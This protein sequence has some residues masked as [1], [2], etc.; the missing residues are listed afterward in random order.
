[1]NCPKCGNPL[2]SNV[3]FCAKCGTPVA[4]Q[5]PMQTQKASADPAVN[6]MSAAKSDGDQKPKKK[7]L[8]LKITAL[9][10]VISVFISG[11]LCVS[12]FFQNKVD[13]DGVVYIDEHLILKQKAELVVFDEENFPAEEYEITV[14]RFLVGGALK[15]ISFR[16]TILTDTS[17]DPVYEIDFG[18]DG[19]YRIT[20]KD[21]T[22]VRTQTTTD[23]TEAEDGKTVIIDVIVDNE[24]EESKDTIDIYHPE[25]QPIQYLEP[26]EE[27]IEFLGHIFSR[28]HYQADTFSP[29]ASDANKIAGEA[30]TNL[31]RP[32]Y[33]DYIERYGWETPENVMHSEQSDPREIY[34]KEFIGHTKYPVEN[35]N[36]LIRNMFNVEPKDTESY[37]SVTDEYGTVYSGCSWYVDGDYYYTY[38]DYVDVD[39]SYSCELIDKTQSET[40][41][42][43]VIFD[44]YSF[45]IYDSWE[46]DYEGVKIATFEVTAGVKEVDGRRVWSFEKWEKSGKADAEDE[47]STENAVEETTETVTTATFEKPADQ[48]NLSSDEKAYYDY[49]YSNYGNDDLVCFADVTHDGKDEMIVG[50]MTMYQQSLIVFTIKNGQV[51]KI[52]ETEALSNSRA[53]FFLTTASGQCNF[54]EEFWAIWSGSGTAGAR[55]FYLTDSGQEVEVKSVEQQFGDIGYGS[56]EVPYEE[57]EAKFDEQIEKNYGKGYST[58]YYFYNLDGAK[59][60]AKT[61]TLSPSVAFG[62]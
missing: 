43:T 21:I 25:T 6:Q 22:S 60:G 33:F 56:P 46:E 37:Y 26:T 27:E 2:S 5:P 38:Y 57:A 35:M 54:V 49:F 59:Q 11:T 16:N 34:A 24:N 17:S 36:W 29:D 18:K 62:K 7:N 30:L 28:M 58:L 53:T 40:N 47:Q 8:A 1:M 48:T 19:E 10:L 42:I 20:L 50:D 39:P 52:Y 23:G 55:E 51:K 31:F 3:K 9:V 41:R 13:E 44:V 14:E 45:S 61:M 12:N 32:V 4:Q 15:N